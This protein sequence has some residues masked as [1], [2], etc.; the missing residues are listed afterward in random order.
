MRTIEIYTDGSHFKGSD[1]VGSGI[2]FTHPDSKNIIY[3]HSAKLNVAKFRDLYSGVT[4]SNPTAELMAA[5]KVME[6]L[7]GITNHKLIIYSDYNGVQNWLKGNWKASKPYIKDI[8]EKGK[9]RMLRLKADGNIIELRW[10]KGHSGDK[11]NDMADDLA[12]KMDNTSSIREYI[13]TL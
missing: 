12:K 10:L 5:V 7:N 6:L 11:M 1:R 9:Q 13:A 4:V 8:T 2:C 3:T